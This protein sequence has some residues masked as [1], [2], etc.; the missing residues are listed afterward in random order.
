[1]KRKIISLF[2]VLLMTLAPSVFG[3]SFG[4]E[5]D[6]ALDKEWVITFNTDIQVESLDGVY[7][8]KQNQPGEIVSDQVTMTSN[9]QLTVEA[10]A[11]G[12]EKGAAY[13][14]HIGEVASSAGIS[15]NSVTTFDFTTIDKETEA[16]T[17]T[18]VIDGDTIEV[19]K[20]GETETVRLLLVDT[21]ETKHPTNPVQPFGKEASQ[22]ATAELEG[23]T[24]QLE[25]DGPKR[26][27]Y[28]RLLAYV[29]IDGEQFNEQLLTEGL[30][31]YAY[32]YNPPYTY[33][34]ELKKAES[35]AR[36][37]ERGIWSIPGY[38]TDDGFQYEEDSTNDGYDGPY[39]PSGN[40][41]DC[42]SFDTHEEAQ[43]FYEAA[44][45]PDADPHRLDRDG[46]GI[47]CESLP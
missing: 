41:R 7:V 38:V 23:K 11:S 8:H 15:M 31:R 2:F 14:L 43:A 19:E 37:A 24:V 40:D 22:F 34:E 29:W 42:S 16:A 25:Y 27:K 28:D 33:S 36:K 20:D 21:P 47:A 6:V 3:E 17:V 32:V 26:D 45:G 10:P 1:M 13:T 46:N 35:E 30:A 12:Y 39:D 18:R 4:T 5:E 9:R 44:G